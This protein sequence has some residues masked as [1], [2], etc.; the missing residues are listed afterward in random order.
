MGQ[1]YNRRIISERLSANC[2]EKLENNFSKN[3]DEE[4]DA[5][6]LSRQKEGA[7]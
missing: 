3:P 2:L 6:V 5:D 4:K 7:H 1:G